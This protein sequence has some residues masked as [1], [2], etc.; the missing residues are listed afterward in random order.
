MWLIINTKM[1]YW[2]WHQH[3]LGYESNYIS[4]RL[5]LLPSVGR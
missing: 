1:A 3:K 2:T 5:N 4:G